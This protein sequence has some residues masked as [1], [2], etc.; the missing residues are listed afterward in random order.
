MGAPSSW[1]LD[2]SRSNGRCD[3]KFYMAGEALRQPPCGTFWPRLTSMRRM[4]S[5]TVLR[6]Q[7]CL[8]SR[9]VRKSSNNIQWRT[10]DQES[11][12]APLFTPASENYLSSDVLPR[13]R[14]CPAA[15]PA[16]FCDKVNCSTSQ[17]PLS[18][19]TALEQIK[20]NL[21]SVYAHPSSVIMHACRYAINF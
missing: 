18:R 15:R 4:Q 8:T 5:S 21:I 10:I 9:N 2:S 20:V 17:S 12:E 13:I 7:M 11:N 6:Q 19:A 1:V 16:G 3:P 14:Q